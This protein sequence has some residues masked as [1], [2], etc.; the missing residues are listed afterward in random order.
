MHALEIIPPEIRLWRAVLGQ[1]YADA[2][3]PP[4]SN[5][6]EAVQRVKARSFLR[7]DTAP[8]R[9]ALEDVCDSANVPLDRIVNWA[10]TQYPAAA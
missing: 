9:E 10:R 6:R 2:E 1:A 5:A 8:D 3:L 4:L 7:A